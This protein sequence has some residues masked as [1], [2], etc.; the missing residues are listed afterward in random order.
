MSDNIHPPKKKVKLKNKI[1]LKKTQL[2]FR[3]PLFNSAI[4]PPKIKKTA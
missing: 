1:F 4:F 2:D 3:N